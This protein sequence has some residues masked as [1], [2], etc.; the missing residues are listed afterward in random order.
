MVSQGEGDFCVLFFCFL[1]V[2]PFTC[3]RTDDT[4]RLQRRGK[5]FGMG[6][7]FLKLYMLRQ[8][9]AVRVGE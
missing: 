2:P 1:V 9:A 6:E 5:G 7:G 8:A 4:E 3:A